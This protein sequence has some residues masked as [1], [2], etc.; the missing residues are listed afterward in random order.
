MEGHDRQRYKAWHRM[1]MI[2]HSNMKRE[3]VS[4]LLKE[5]K[6]DLLVFYEILL[7]VFIAST[8][9]PGGLILKM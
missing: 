6:F 1:M 2:N 8:L 5:V 3:E 9:T 4:V 7:L